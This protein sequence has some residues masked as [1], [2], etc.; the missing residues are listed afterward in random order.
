MINLF[1]KSKQIE[2][3][4]R[5]CIFSEVSEKKQRF[6]N[7]SKVKCFEN[8]ISTLDRDIANVTFF[9]D[10]AHGVLKDHFLSKTSEKIVPI[11]EGSETGAFLRLLE[12]VENQNF[13][14]DTIIYFLEDD[15]L[16]RK[17]YLNVMIEAF[18]DLPIDYLTL[19][20]HKDKYFFKQYEN[21]KSK[22]FHTK[23]TH[24]R[25]TPSTTNTYAMRYKTL[26][27]DMEIHRK[28]SL[29]RRISSDHEKF[30]ELT[31]KGYILVSP[32]PGWSTHCEPKYASP[33]IDWDTI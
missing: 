18:N 15:Y 32:I 7:F 4:V 14:E 17:G 29:N 8:F 16:H 13:K 2:I 27:R 33:C 11:T 30:L 20:D 21:L 31:E 19:Y 12:Y 1:K 9:L 6:S 26:K 5:H 24:W 22:V 3:F 23:S 28:Y 10:L 25:T